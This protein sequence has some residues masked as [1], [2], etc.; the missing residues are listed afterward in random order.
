MVTFEDMTDFTS[1]LCAG[2]PNV[3]TTPLEL[4]AEYIDLYPFNT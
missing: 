2:A 4:K 1:D 3:E